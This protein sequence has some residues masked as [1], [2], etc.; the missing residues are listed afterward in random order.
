VQEAQEA[1][2]GG[3]RQEEEEEVQEAEEALRNM[4]NRRIRRILCGVIVGV[5]VIAPSASAATLIG[6]YQFQGTTSSSGPGPS[7]TAIDTGNTFQ[8]DTV[9][10]VSRKVLAFP[11]GSGLQMAPALITGDYSEVATFRLDAT[12]GYRRIFDSTNG[13][14]AGLYDYSG[15]LDF[16][17]AGDVDHYSGPAALLSDNTYA[18]VALVVG[19]SPASISSYVNGAFAL[20]FAGAYPLTA[21]TLRFFKDDA[22]EQSAG[23]VSCI[24][25]YSGALSQAEVAAIGASPTCAAPSAPPAHKRCK[26][27]KGHHRSAES[28]KKK[29][30]KKRKKR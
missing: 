15:M 28:A 27:R 13:G 24:R 22:F 11:E 5:G 16:F 17:D 12:S 23:A 26:K 9:M 7:L 29:K 1:P 2:L 18:T 20:Q 3:V 4:R 19:G 14:N 30:C 21:D 8:Q 25:I 10:G 6:N